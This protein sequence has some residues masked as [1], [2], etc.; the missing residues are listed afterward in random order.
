MDFGIG[1]TSGVEAWRV[2]ERAETLGF[3]HA[4]FVDTQ[5][6]CADLFASMAVAAVHTGRIRLGTGVLVP[7]NRIAPVTANGLATLNKLAPGRIDFGVGTGFTARNTMGLGAM[8]LAELREHVRVV[9]GLLS[10]QTVECDLEGQRRKVRFLNPDAGLVDID[11]PIPL[12]LSAFGPRARALA[13][14]IADG[15]LHFVGRLSAGLRAAGEMAE[16]CRA[17]GRDPASLYKTACV[18]GCV[19]AEGEGSDSP[20]ARA[21]AGPFALTFFHSIMD[22]SL[23]LRIPSSLATAVA[24]YRAVYEAYEPADARY[25]QLHRGHFMFPRPDEQRFLTAEL[26][27]DL[28]FTATAGELRE[29]IRALREAGHAQ[30]TVFLA[31]GH[32]DAIKDWARLFEKV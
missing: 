19:L 8:R 14:E 9:R 11:H 27:R 28:T 22:G 3:T 16:A 25:L 32:E 20:R 24:E 2:V 21:Q 15:W 18:M 1:V 5:L 26:L 7:S 13:A 29:R 31:P 4:W 23:R 10:G 30:L 12:H 17:A 6:L